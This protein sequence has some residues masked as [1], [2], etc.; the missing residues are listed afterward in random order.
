MTTTE[1]DR[2]EAL[3]AARR[4]AASRGAQDGGRR[5]PGTATALA[6]TGAAVGGG[7]ALVGLMVASARTGEPGDTTATPGLPAATPASPLEEGGG[8]Q[9]TIVVRRI[10]IPVEGARTGSA[11][12]PGAPAVPLTTTDTAPV[13]R[14]NGS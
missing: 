9:H 2:T 1:R 8:D 10:V 11:I 12:T 7:L 4:L 6:A 14:S 3:A 13:T 5:R